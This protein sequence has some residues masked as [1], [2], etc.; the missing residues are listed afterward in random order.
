MKKELKWIRPHYAVKSNPIS[1]IMEIMVENGL[2]FD[3]ASKMEIKLAL[4]MGAS[5]KDIIYSNS[6]KNETDII[7]ADQMG[8]EYT[9]ADSIDEIIK[10][11]Q[12][13]KNM[14]VLWRI[15]IKEKN[16]E[17][18]K[19]IFSNKFGDDLDLNQ[20]DKLKEKM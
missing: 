4:K 14:K 15:S 7:Y 1:E 18:L 16:S 19:T 2:G 13:N 10:L 5:P 6:V 12:H 9:T 8:V 3:C 20:M 17:E 11:S